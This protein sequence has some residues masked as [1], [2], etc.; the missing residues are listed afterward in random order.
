MYSRADVGETSNQEDQERF[1]SN[2]FYISMGLKFVV[3]F[4]G[5]CGMLLFNKSWRNASSKFVNNMRDRIYVMTRVYKPKLL[6][7]TKS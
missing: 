4:W 6:R 2:E 5:V 1:V 7:M 3:G